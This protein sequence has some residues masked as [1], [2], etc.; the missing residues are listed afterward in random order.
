MC[1][2]FTFLLEHVW[3]AGIELLIR[4]LCN[5]LVVQLSEISIPHYLTASIFTAQSR[6]I[7]VFHRN[8]RLLIVL[9]IT[10]GICRSKSCM[11]KLPFFLVWSNYCFFFLFFSINLSF[12]S[13]DGSCIILFHFIVNLACHE[14]VARL[15]EKLFFF[16]FGWRVKIKRTSMSG[17]VPKEFNVI[18]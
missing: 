3:K 7:A 17:L 14:N 6:D 13:W 2:S 15:V 9:C 4:I 12:F 18:E 10:S 8:V 11:V 1:K 5:I 16:F